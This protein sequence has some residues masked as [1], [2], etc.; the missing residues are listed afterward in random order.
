M[1]SAVLP[2]G[3]AVGGE[4]RAARAT[5]T[6]LWVFIGV[7]SALFALFITAYA[8]RMD[9]SDWSALAMPWQLWLSTALL[10]LASVALQAAK[11]AAQAGRW[12]RARTLLWIGGAGA[13]AFLGS[14]WWAWQDLN[15][16]RVVLAGNPAASFFYLLT[17]MHGLHLLGGLAA[18][19]VTAQLAWER[20]D[21]ARVSL[22]IAL[23][24]RYWHFLLAV[25]VVL[26]AALGWLTPEI[27]RFICGRS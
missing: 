27:V 2:H 6:G 9:S 16:A 17:A 19:A 1:N 24:A 8:M 14:Q 25:W 10:G 23:C 5:S 15:A 7:A 18:W 12:P 13:L 26:F 20:A 4:T 21:L 11:T 22:R 3:G